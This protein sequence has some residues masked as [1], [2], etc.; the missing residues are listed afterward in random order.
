MKK[1]ALVLVFAL[2]LT[3]SLV[4][5][6]NTAAKDSD[7]DINIDLGTKPEDNKDN[8]PDANVE[9]GCVYE[10]YTYNHYVDE[11]YI[12]ITNY[13][14]DVVLVEDDEEKD[15]DEEE[16]IE[17]VALTIPSEINGVPV[18][19][20]AKG[21]FEKSATLGS[22]KIPASV[23]E[24]GAEA[25]WFCP[26]LEKIELPAGLTKIGAR[27]FAYCTS[28][29]ELTLP[30]S[31]T[32]VSEGLCLENKALTKVTLGSKVD[33]IGEKAFAYCINLT[34]INSSSVKNV[35]EDAFK[36]CTALNS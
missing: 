20:I 25:F 17:T 3:A 35:A 24:I 29:T 7:A 21:A 34:S 10:K 19:K 4:S 18:K 28:L 22:V 26:L 27:A 8:K 32:E 14:F 2:L 23:T 36:W 5:C 16:K 12:E 11:K 6:G 1:L 33:S 30:D 13:K 9:Y 31:V 15:D